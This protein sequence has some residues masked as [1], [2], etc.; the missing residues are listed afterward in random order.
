MPPKSKKEPQNNEE[1]K[2]S[3]TSNSKLIPKNGNLELTRSIQKI[4]K[5]QKDFMES[6]SSLSGYTE[7]TLN[8]LV[9]QI[10]SKQNEIENLKEEYDNRRKSYDIETNLYYAEHKYLGALNFLRDRKEVAI[11]EKDLDDMKNKIIHLS[12]NQDEELKKAIDAEKSLANKSLHASLQNLELKHKADIAELNANVKQQTNEIKNLH[13]TIANLK[14]EI[15]AQRE[16]TKEVAIA[17]KQGGVHQS[18]GK[19]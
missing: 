16:L 19:Q 10:E 2:T 11:N 13:S 12:K 17:S 15:S 3:K 1:Q 6:V 14:E 18:F 5:T 8:D 7:D 9:L 4:I